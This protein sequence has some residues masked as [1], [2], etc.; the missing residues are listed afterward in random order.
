MAAERLVTIAELQAEVRD[1][2]RARTTAA[3]LPGASPLPA[4]TPATPGVG[5]TW[6]SDEGSGEGGSDEEGDD[7]EDCEEAQVHR[8]FHPMQATLLLVWRLQ[9]LI[10]DADAS[11][12]PMATSVLVSH[13][14]RM[15]I[16]S[17]CTAKMSA[18]TKI[19]G[20]H[21]DQ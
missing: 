8:Y 19:D 9:R 5:G 20:D 18:A 4:G 10:I 21:A 6:P 3:A 16:N 15:H 17:C 14:S 13:V 2:K 1:L 12:P 7:E 11:Y